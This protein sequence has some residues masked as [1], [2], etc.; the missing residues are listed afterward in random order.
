ME[1][2]LPCVTYVLALICVLGFLHTQ[3]GAVEV[4]AVVDTQLDA[5]ARTLRRHPYLQL[6]PLLE[7]RITPEQAGLMRR[8]HERD[9]VERAA[10][11]V[12]RGVILRQQAELDRMI[13]ATKQRIESHPAWKFGARATERH[14]LTFLTHVFFHGGV[15]HLFANLGV[16][17]LIGRVLEGAWGGA[18]HACVVAAGALGGMAAFFYQ[19]P[20]YADPIIGTSGLASGL[21][22]AFAVRFANERGRVIYAPSLL[23][24]ALAL[25]LPVWLG[26]EGSIARGE[27]ADPAR[28]GAWNPSMA[29]LMGGFAGGALAALGV[30]LLGLEGRIERAEL[31]AALRAPTTDSGLERAIQEHNAGDAERAY[32]HLVE[33]VKRD[34]GNRD[35]VLAFWDVC[36]DLRRAHEAAPA[37]IGL[38]REALRSGAEADAV[39]YWLRLVT[40]EL[41]TE[42]EIALLLRMAPLLRDAGE[43]VAARR[44]LLSAL[45][46][47]NED[48]TVVARVAEEAA[49]LDP[50]LVREAA[51]RALGSAGLGLEERRALEQRLA[52]L[53]QSTAASEGMRLGHVYRPAGVALPEGAEPSV[54]GSGGIDFEEESRELHCLEAV[55]VRLDTEGLRIEFDGAG[56]RVRFERMKA[57]AVAVVPGLASK[58]VIVIDLVLN[59][60]SLGDAPLQVVRLRTDRFDIR[61]LS[62]GAEDPLAAV[63][64]FVGQLVG[65]S[66][67]APLPD[68]ASVAGTPFASFKSLSAYH[69]DVLGTFEPDEV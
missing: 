22:G 55:P 1:R 46:R 47:G 64:A 52:S 12:P 49:D 48:P 33:R 17:I 7:K 25:W 15:L 5:A 6:P 4:E 60:G 36:C 56:K 41:D 27:A 30:R 16:L 20:F 51:K 63:R 42:A 26:F 8:D 3:F 13:A 23:L 2:R 58:K 11:P 66:G 67:A 34:A 24:A 43:S 53:P 39:E 9:R 54:V 35:V 14:P 62:A 61:A 37:L 31:Q 10:P 38:I 45:E 28:L 40:S 50:D 57:V 21:V 29:L 59:W 68:A 44:A 18:V 69:R 65:R 32:R 19:H